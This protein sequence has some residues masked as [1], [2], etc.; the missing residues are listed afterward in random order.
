ML[1]IGTSGSVGGEGGNILAYPAQKDARR[2]RA[3]T[4][5]GLEASQCRFSRNPRA[6]GACAPGRKRQRAGGR[7]AASAA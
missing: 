3:C 2:W 1:E 5:T 6:C 7:Y 4:A